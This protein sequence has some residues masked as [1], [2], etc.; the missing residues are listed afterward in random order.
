MEIQEDHIEPKII[1]EW[2]NKHFTIEGKPKSVED[3]YKVAKKIDDS[4]DTSRIIFL[5]KDEDDEDD[6][7]KVETQDEFKSALKF[8]QIEGNETLHFFVVDKGYEQIDEREKEEEEDEVFFT[9]IGDE[10]EY[11]MVSEDEKSM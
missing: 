5:Y 4:I 3:V 9:P 1:L 11:E 7:I 10:L 6:W 8:A 2:N